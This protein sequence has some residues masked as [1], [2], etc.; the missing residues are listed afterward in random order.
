MRSL[1][2]PRPLNSTLSSRRD[3]SFAA[4][5]ESRKATRTVPSPIAQRLSTSKPNTPPTLIIIAERPEP[6]KATLDG[7]IDDFS[8]AI[9]LNPKFARAWYNRGSQTG[10]KGDVEAAMADFNKAIELNPQYAEA[11][12]NRAMVRSQKCDWEGAI[13]DCTKAIELKP[14]FAELYNNRGY[15]RLSR[16]N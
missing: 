4:R 10:Q 5:P 14:G 6:K 8:T 9:H 13:A 1:M 15:A 12:N 7:A 11:Y 16:L 2:A 3:T